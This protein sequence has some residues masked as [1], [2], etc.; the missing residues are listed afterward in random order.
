MKSNSKFSSF[1]IL[2][3]FFNPSFIFSEEDFSSFNISKKLILIVSLFIFSVV[4]SVIV[5]IFQPE[6]ISGLTVSSFNIFYII[7]F[8][9]IWKNTFFF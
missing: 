5:G 7:Y 9:Q 8:K 2:N 1:G 3:A 6:Y 4:Y